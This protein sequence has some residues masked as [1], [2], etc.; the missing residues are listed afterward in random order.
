M[1]EAIAARRRMFQFREFPS[2][3]AHQSNTERTDL[4]W[5]KTAMGQTAWDQ[6]VWDQMAWHQTVKTEEVQVTVLAA[7]ATVLEDPVGQDLAK[8][9]L[10]DHPEAQ[11]V[12]A[13]PAVWIQI[14]PRGLIRVL[15]AAVLQC[16]LQLAVQGL[17]QLAVLE[18]RLCEARQCQWGHN[19]QEVSIPM[20]FPLIPLRS[21]LG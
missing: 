6:M 7:L 4:R 12:P 19:L 2:A 5:H 13:C 9:R 14:R 16:L 1:K 3:L 20:L 17:R 15:V 18:G 8:G 11:C 21:V 10:W